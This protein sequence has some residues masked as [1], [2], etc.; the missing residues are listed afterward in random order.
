MV[1]LW[2]DIQ[3]AL[4]AGLNLVHLTAEPV[5]VAAVSRQCFGRSCERVLAKDPATYDM[6]TRHARIFGVAG[7]YQYN[8]RETIQAIRA[9]AQ[10]EPLAIESQGMK[11]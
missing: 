11:P 2:Y 6:R 4:N 9:Y 8:S 7:H 5:T 3:I 10:S 1:N